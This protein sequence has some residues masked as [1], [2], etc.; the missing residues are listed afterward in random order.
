MTAGWL[1]QWPS[2]MSDTRPF[3]IGYQTTRAYYAVGG[4]GTNVLIF[5]VH[6]DTLEIRDFI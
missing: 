6:L 5:H 3:A 2:K 4:E 1:V